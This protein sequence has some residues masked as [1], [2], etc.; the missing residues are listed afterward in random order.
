MGDSPFLTPYAGASGWGSGVRKARPGAVKELFAHRR[1]SF[2]HCFLGIF[3]LEK[4]SI[5]GEDRN[6]PVIPRCHGT[7]LGQF[8]RCQRRCRWRDVR[9][10]HCG[11]HVPPGSACPGPRGASRKCSRKPP[12]CLLGVL[13]PSE[14]RRGPG[15]RLAVCARLCPVPWEGRVPLLP[16][17]LVH[18]SQLPPTVLPHGAVRSLQ[19]Q[20]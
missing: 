13:A 2:L 18:A 11:C 20:K 16:L 14:R 1:G 10:S 6:C 7:R 4:V 3:H 19:L 15:S 9:K 17:R 5:W 12:R 8:L